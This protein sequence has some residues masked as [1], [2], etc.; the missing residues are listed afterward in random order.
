VILLSPF[1]RKIL[2]RLS[3]TRKKRLLKYNLVHFTVL[4][5]IGEAKLKSPIIATVDQLTQEPYALVLCFPK[6]SE[7]ELQNRLEELRTLGVTALEFFGK[8]SVF[9]VPLPVLG[10]GF[11]G[12]VVIAHLNGQK[13]AV[14]IRRVDAD[15]IDLFHEARMLT[16]ANSA[17]VAPKLFAASKNFLL[18]QL[19]EGDL[20][21]DWLKTDRDKVAV[22]RVLG[23]VLE[24]CFR[25]DEI[26]LDHGE[27]SKAPKHVIVDRQMKPW[28]VDFETASDARKPSNVSAMGS[29]LFTSAGEVA[30]N[31]AAVLGERNKE[32]IVAA[33]KNY[34]KERTRLG[35]ERVLQVCLG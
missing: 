21:P 24:Q 30:R 7:A 11:V 22:M 29:F 27:L 3:G 26:G 25:M 10:K 19:I 32:E 17:N 6:P 8:A 28:I 12:I 5:L 4:L 9:G 13:V 2:W 31:V 14:K 15:R 33:M 23:E 1:G 16:K 20:L 35:F 34:R 18:M